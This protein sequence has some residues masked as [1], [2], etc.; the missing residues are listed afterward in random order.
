V[1]QVHGLRIITELLNLLAIV[2]DLWIYSP[3]TVVGWWQRSEKVTMEHGDF[4]AFSKES[5]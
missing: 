1:K 3:T 2:E 4:R 5:A